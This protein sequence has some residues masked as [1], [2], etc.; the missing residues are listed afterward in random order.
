MDVET[1]RRIDKGRMYEAYDDWPRL[2]RE[3]Y[4]A[5]MQA[6]DV[7]AITHV[8][9]A[10]M[11]GSGAISD[12]FAALLSKTGIHVEVVKGYQLPRTVTAE[13]LVVV[14]SISGNTEETLGAL[15]DAVGRGCRV[16]A[17]SDGGRLK[18][19]CSK[20]GLEH[21]RVAARHSPRASFP[22]F[23]FSMIRALEPLLPVSG[24]D[25]AAALRN[26]EAVGKKI[27]SSSLDG[28]NPALS[29]AWWITGVPL[30]YYPWGLRAAAIRFKNSLQ[31]NAKMHTIAEDVIEACHNG[32]VPFSSQSAV[33]PILIR[34]ADDHWKT[35]E[36]WSILKEFFEGV[37]ISYRE[38]SSSNGSILEKLTGL[39]YLLDYATIYRAV[40]SGIDPTPID[41]I[42]F[43]KS[44]LTD[45]KWSP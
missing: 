32:V 43:I 27:S 7:E 40:I 16:L 37:D 29:L 12:T 8:V 44:K 15:S 35:K 3:H 6:A 23:L 1:L 24:S 41:P 21:R 18:E 5:D 36:R 38:I 20:R 34:G 39:I 4:E 22:A 14:I 42:D 25:V 31:E 9:F 13:S 45:P 2:A 33:R 28:K 19:I 17:F 11:G 10:G 26:L 30:V